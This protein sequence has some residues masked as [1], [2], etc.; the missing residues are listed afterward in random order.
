MPDNTL[1]N[2]RQVNTAGRIGYFLLNL[3]NAFPIAIPTFLILFGTQ[4]LGLKIGLISLMMALVKVF[5]G[6]TDIVAGVL[7]DKTHHKN[8]KARPWL[9][10]MSL[11][12][13]LCLA[14][15]FWIPASW[16]TTLKAVMLIVFYTLTV[17]VFGT[18]VG[19]A[20][21]ALLP[22]M[23]TSDKERG[24]LGAICGGAGVT[25]CGFLMAA[26]FPL[27]ARLGITGTFTLFG[28]IVFVLTLIGYFLV[29]ELPY[30]VIEAAT[31]GHGEKITLR[32]M[33]SNLAHNKYA[34]LLCLFTLI[35]QAG[36]SFIQGCGTYYAIYVLGNQ[37]WYTKFMLCGSF[38]SLAGMFVSAALV[39][40]FGSKFV[41]TVGCLMAV[42]GFA[43]I[44]I[45]GD[46]PVVVIV[47]FFFILMGGQV[48]TNGQGGVLNAQ[49]VDY[50][51]W[52]NGIRGEGVISCAGNVGN[53]IGS[54]VGTALM[55]GM[56]AAFGFIEGGVEQTAS[57]VQGIKMTYTVATP[58]I[59]LILAVAFA[60]AWG[61]QKMMPKIQS[62]LAERRQAAAK[63]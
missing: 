14:A 20:I 59:Y 38:G 60:A 11:P 35:I 15:E 41:Y 13:A 37:G 25:L 29:R 56:L 24:T 52:K 62:E 54:A 39:R 43:I 47:M 16:G 32:A 42:V 51:E 58:V 61:L 30:E 18:V 45:S 23:T 17:S 10:W 2:S 28:G 5:D 31:K 27:Q 4:T 19:I 50:G 22:R 53:K 7:I 9:L 33:A 49:A 46:N 6:F 36:G 12:F 3:T 26:V 40:K 34:L 63:K 55:G 8:G 57:A 44:R 48:F 21:R 1:M